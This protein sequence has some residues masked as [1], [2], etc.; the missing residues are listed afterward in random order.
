[1]K[2]KHV[3]QRLRKS[4]MLKKMLTIMKLTTLLF[5]FALMWNLWIGPA[6]KRAYDPA[7]TPW[8][9]R[10]FWDFGTGALGDMACHIM[11]P[12]Y[13]ALGLKYPSDVSASSTLSNLYSPPQAQI[14]SY[15]FPARPARGNVN[16]PEVK[17]YWYDGGL[18]PDRPA[19][20]KDGEMM[21]DENGGIIFTVGTAG[22]SPG[23]D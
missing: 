19:E 10:G 21:G 23:M 3:E 12:L 22:T 9:W 5:F 15:T 11:D 18:L 2:K 8:N 1:M 16:M 4:L 20:L 7:Y 6:K 14:V 13:W 17:V